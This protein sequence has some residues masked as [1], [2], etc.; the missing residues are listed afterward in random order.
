MKNIVNVV[1]VNCLFKKFKFKSYFNLS[2][3]VTYL[4]NKGLTHLFFDTS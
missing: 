2:G 4:I 3:Y 1:F